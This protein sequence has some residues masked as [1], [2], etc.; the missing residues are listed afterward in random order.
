MR[1]LTKKSFFYKNIS[2]VCKSLSSAVLPMFKEPGNQCLFLIAL[3][4]ITWFG[5]ISITENKE[6][7]QG[8]GEKKREY[9]RSLLKV[10]E[11]DRNKYSEQSPVHCTS[12][13]PGIWLLNC[14]FLNRVIFNSP[15]SVINN[16]LV[17]CLP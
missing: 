5:Q 17:P 7:R 16:S 1:T 13:F 14:F 3:L 8:K 15:E 11:N 6:R 4:Y 2:Y 10:T 12:V 9:T